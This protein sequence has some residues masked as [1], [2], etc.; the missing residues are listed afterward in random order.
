[1]K[2]FSH[3]SPVRDRLETMYRSY[4]PWWPRGHRDLSVMGR[5]WFISPLWVVTDCA[6][7][8]RIY[9]VIGYNGVAAA[10]YARGVFPK[11]RIT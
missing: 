3:C 8:S 4:S 2:R 10:A 9:L 5:M 1:M 6:N 7:F 11:R